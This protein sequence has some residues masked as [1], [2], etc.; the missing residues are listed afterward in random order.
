MNPIESFTLDHTKLVPG[1][2]ERYTKGNVKTW[3]IRFK[4]PNSG[5]YIKPEVSHTL[6]HFLATYLKN[7]MK[8][9]IYG[10]FPMGCLTGFYV[11]TTESVTE[12]DLASGLL[13]SHAYIESSESI[14]GASIESCGNYKFQDLNGAKEEMNKFYNSV[15]VKYEETLCKDLCSKDYVKENNND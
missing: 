11:L 8:G 4:Y 3:D 1:I 13:G 5:D 2:Y 7:T 10:V 6:E 9:L 14:P 12:D 15:L